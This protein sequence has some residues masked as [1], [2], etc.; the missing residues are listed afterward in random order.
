[1][2]EDWEIPLIAASSIF[3]VA[4]FLCVICPGG[5]LYKCLCGV[6]ID[7]DGDG[8]DTAGDNGDGDD[9]A[10]VNGDGDGADTAGDNGDGDDTAVCHLIL[11]IFCAINYH[12]SQIWGHIQYLF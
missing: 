6:S 4:I 11:G 5:V 1:M 2:M 9:T 12:N 8:A 3:A 7:S 10:G